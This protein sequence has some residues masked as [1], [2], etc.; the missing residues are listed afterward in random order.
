MRQRAGDIKD[1]TLGH[2][3]CNLKWWRRVIDAWGVLS[4]RAFACWY[5]AQGGLGHGIR[6]AESSSMISGRHRH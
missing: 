4:G 3:M 5:S 2:P 6:D 1:G